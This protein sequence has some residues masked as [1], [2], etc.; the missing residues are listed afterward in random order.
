MDKLEGKIKGNF[1][2]FTS[3]YASTPD[4]WCGFLYESVCVDRLELGRRFKMSFLTAP[5]P[6]LA[7]MRA[8]GEAA[9]PARREVK[10]VTVRD[11]VLNKRA[12]K[13]GYFAALV[14]YLLVNVGAVQLE[15]VQPDWLKARLEASP[16]WVRQT[17]AEYKHCNPCYVRF[18]RGEGDFSLF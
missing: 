3:K 6:D 2:A 17:P 11:I 8:Q 13:K 5:F 7:T 15:A 10:Q 1:E 18:A 14:E 4:E 9:F 12:R 16:L